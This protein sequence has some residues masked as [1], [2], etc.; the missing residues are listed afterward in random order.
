MPSISKTCLVFGW[1]TSIKKNYCSCNIALASQQIITH[2]F[3]LQQTSKRM[4]TYCI[5]KCLSIEEW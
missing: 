5:K 3:L 1:V 2:Y 4:T